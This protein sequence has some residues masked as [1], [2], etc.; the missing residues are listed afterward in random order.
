MGKRS[1]KQ[2][3]KELFQLFLIFFK[4]G[5]FSFGGG[6]AM[7]ALIEGEVVDKKHWLTHAELNEVFAIAESTPGPI[8]INTATFIGAKRLGVFGGIFATL[9]VVIPSF[10]IIVALSYV[11]DLVKD[12]KWVGFLFRGIRVG[13][14]VLIAKAVLSFFKNMRKTLFSFA[15]CLAAFV[16]VFLVK[17]D[18]IYVILGTIV[19]C[20]IVVAWTSYWR[21]HHL[22]MLGT[23][24]YYNENVGKPLE[25]DEYASEKAI[26]DGIVIVKSAEKEEGKV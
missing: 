22:H 16:L 3:F 2:Y 12:N 13:V 25:K 14:L 20:S 5:L 17:V 26:D 23:P 10:A 6:Y 21:S 8:A 4:I 7:L 1:A 11:I 9:G 15:L 24:E 19:L 18:V